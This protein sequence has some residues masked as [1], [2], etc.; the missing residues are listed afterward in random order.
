MSAKE[1]IFQT[2]HVHCPT[3][4]M[5]LF[6]KV[7]FIAITITIIMTISIII[8]INPMKDEYHTRHKKS[9]SNHVHAKA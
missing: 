7:I 1:E 8:V 6:L 4:L 9:Q 2:N 5:S 3:R